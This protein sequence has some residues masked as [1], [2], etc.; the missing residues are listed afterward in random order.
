MTMTTMTKHTEGT[1]QGRAMRI[2]RTFVFACA[3]A[4]V[5]AAAPA[6]ADYCSDN[7]PGTSCQASCGAGQTPVDSCQ[8]DDGTNGAC[9]SAGSYNPAGE[10]CP[11]NGTCVPGDSCA[12]GQTESGSCLTS[13]YTP[14]T[15]CSNHQIVTPSDTA[16]ACANAGGACVF[17]SSKCASGQSAFPLTCS[18]SFG[19]TH[20]CCGPTAV[21]NTYNKQ[22]PA[23][24]GTPATPSASAGGILNLPSC[25][26]TGNCG[27]DDIVR[28]GVNFANLL[29]GLSGALFL[30]AFVYGGS[31]YLLS[32][33]RAKWIEKGSHAMVQAA[34]GMMIVLGSWTIVNYIASSI[35]GKPI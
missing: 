33:G 20:P 12:S 15:C 13:N 29:F 4:L 3:A 10:A 19:G 5:L 31:M 35:T 16:A 2:A 30:V 8:L 21:V 14:G 27:L 17:G 9:C 34:F 25:I 28:T 26:G 1:K 32:F 11:Y 7:Y 24:G 22:N 18:D 23:S 6:L